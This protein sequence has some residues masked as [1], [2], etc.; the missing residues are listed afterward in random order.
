MHRVGEFRDCGLGLFSLMSPAGAVCTVT[1][2]VAVIVTL[3]CPRTT[4]V[5]SQGTMQPPPPPPQQQLQH[6]THTCQCRL[7]LSSSTIKA[8]TALIAP[9]MKPHMII[10]AIAPPPMHMLMHMNLQGRKMQVRPMHM[11]FSRLLSQRWQLR[12]SWAV[13]TLSALSVWRL[14]CSGWRHPV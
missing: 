7:Q 4:L 13:A 6:L 9:H 11:R 2:A 1:P 12:G 14:S 10:M 5:L 3:T 8:V